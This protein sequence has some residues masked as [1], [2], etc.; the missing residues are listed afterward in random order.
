MFPALAGGF[1]T[2]GPPGKSFFQDLFLFIFGCSGS[3]LLRGS[4][5]AAVSRGYAS[6]AIAVRRLL[7]AVAYLD[8]EQRL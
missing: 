5:L 6:F 3:S 4:S 7:I 2:T 1:L 8:V